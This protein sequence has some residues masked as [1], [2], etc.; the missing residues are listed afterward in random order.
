M[1]DCDWLSDR[2]PPVALGQAEWT[3]D[4]I[5]H[6]NG[7]PS[8]RQEWELVQTT[9]RLGEGLVGASEVAARPQIVLERLRRS[10]RQRRWRRTWGF[11]GLAAAAGLAAL[12]WS[13]RGE[14]VPAS[15]SEPVV[16][17]LQLPLPELEELQP[18]EL[19]SVLQ[20]MDEPAPAPEASALED[21]ELGDLDS[22][23]LEN[24]LDYWEG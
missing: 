9:S 8:C 4:E 13:G 10:A 15:P 16:A 7:C 19:D 21:P 14:S 12:L 17:G 23:E 3:A 2:M 5:R 18:A 1:N 24:V 6:L 11:G 22:E 20:A